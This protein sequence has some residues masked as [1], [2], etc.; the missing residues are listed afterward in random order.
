M[1]LLSRILLFESLRQIYDHQEA[2]ESLGNRLSVIS[3]LESLAPEESRASSSNPV[4]TE[5]S[6]RSNRESGIETAGKVLV[7]DILARVIGFF[8]LLVNT[9][10]FPLCKPIIY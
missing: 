1:I 3:N 10:S 7:G 6:N 2:L 4:I 5:R 9:R 8:S